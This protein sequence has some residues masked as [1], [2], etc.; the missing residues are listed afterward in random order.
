MLDIRL[1]MLELGPS[2]KGELQ[3]TRIKTGLEIKPWSW[4]L[5]LGSHVHYVLLFFIDFL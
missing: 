3:E 1:E 4:L 5:F 2:A